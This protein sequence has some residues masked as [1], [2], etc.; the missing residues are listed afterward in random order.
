[1]LLA[2]ERWDVIDVAVAACG[3]DEQIAKAK[4][5]VAGKAPVKRNRFIQVSGGARTVN[6]EL[7]AKART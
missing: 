2:A 1:M 4:K 7:E 5:A 3:I 6:R